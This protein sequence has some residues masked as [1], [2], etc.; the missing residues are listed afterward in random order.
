MSTRNI[1]ELDSELY[2]TLL[3]ADRMDVVDS[4]LIS[5]AGADKIPPDT[6]NRTILIGLGGTGMKT[7]NHIKRVV[8]QKLQPQWTK[9][10]AFLA[11]DSDR[12]EFDKAAYLEEYEF[13]L[14]T[15]PGI[16]EAVDHGKK[17]YPSAWLP[18]VD[19]KKAKELHDYGG[20]GAGRKRLMGKMKIHFASADKRGVDQD[21]V[22]RISD[23]KA[24]RLASITDGAKYQ[25]YVIGSL[26]GG[27]CSGGFLEMPAMIRKALNMGSLVEINAMLYLPDTV[28][29]LQSEINIKKELMANGYASLKELNYFQGM[30][31]RDG[32]SEVWPNNDSAN[33]ELKLEST[34][35]FF[36]MPYLIGTIG[37]PKSDS[38]KVAR[39]TIAEFFISLLGN[40]IP[41]EAAE[42]AFLM[43]SFLN[44]AK[45]GINYKPNN[46]AYDNGEVEAPKTAH[47]FP[48]RYGTI[49]FAQASAPQQIIRAYTV[50]KACVRAGLCPISNQ[51]RKDRIAAGET[52]LP[53]LGE[54][55]Y[56]SP[57]ELNQQR[58]EILASLTA[59][60]SRFQSA[61]FSYAN[62]IPGGA[63]TW[64]AIREGTADDS[65]VKRTVDAFVNKATNSAASKAME[66]GVQE[67]FKKFRTAVKLYVEKNGPM[68]FYNLYHG[69][70]AAEDGG[71]AAKGI[72]EVLQL[73]VDDQHVETGNPNVWPNYKN[74][75]KQ[76]NNLTQE[77]VKAKGGLI[78][79]LVNTFNDD[80]TKQA[81]Q[82]TSAYNAMVN[83][84]INEKRREFMLGKNGILRKNFFEPADTLARQLYAFGKILEAMSRGY[85]ESGSK[86]DDYNTFT[87]V[88]DN[89]TEVNIAALNP[90]AHQWLQDEA[91]ENAA[92][93]EGAKVRKSLVD[94]FFDKTSEWLTV[95]DNLIK[96]TGG[97]VSLVSDDTPVAA[98][99]MFDQCL[100]EAI[101]TKMDVTVGNLFLQLDDRGVDYKTYAKQIVDELALK[102]Q[103]LLNVN[104]SHGGMDRH[105]YI[106]YP[107]SL[108]KN[109]P[110]I[111]AA[112]DAAA[113]QKF[114]KIGVYGTDYADSIMMYQMVAPFEIYHLNDLPAWEREYEVM[115]KNQ[116]HGLH[117]MS[118]DVKREVS[119]D[120]A[121]KY[122]E[123]TS[124]YDYPAITYR[125]NPQEK[126]ED[127]NICHEGQVRNAMD[128]VIDEAIKMGLLFCEQDDDGMYYVYRIRMDN[129]V[130]WDFDEDL[131]RID[132]KTEMYPM[133]A[134][135]I[136]TVAKQNRVK[137]ADITRPV[138]LAYAGQMSRGHVDAEWAWKYARRVLY[139]HRPMFIQIRDTI[140]RVRPWNE[141]VAEMNKALMNKYKPA[142]M[143][144]MMMAKVFFPDEDNIWLLNDEDGMETPV[145]NMSDSALN[146]L[147]RRDPMG[148]AIVEAGFSLYYIYTKLADK[149]SDEELDAALS[150]AKTVL[151]EYRDE[152]TLDEAFDFTDKMMKTQTKALL[153]MGADLE[154]PEKKPLKAFVN[155]MAAVEIEDEETIMAICDFYSK[156]KFW[157]K[158]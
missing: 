72:R 36:D 116:G 102:S 9:Y 101:T 145:V 19:E 77:I 106:M 103:P 35:D 34:D 93:V 17:E 56:S 148:A 137:L 150:Y 157:K 135:L 81:G 66:A 143:I 57:A 88:S 6:H 30:G 98:R 136:K 18:F 85:M 44:N 40:M 15:Q 155:K 29:A 45:Q 42:D 67:E 129:S 127:G 73:M 115:I 4:A 90:T 112:I 74:L 138:S 62:V 152:E 89:S 61:S 156:L 147:T 1:Y 111:A 113:Q 69:N 39:E 31:M 12:S 55:Q 21:I 37:G 23:M 49:G 64:D 144:R 43:N 41:P 7:L 75:E 24:N 26:S 123:F 54:K 131:L 124:W 2:G 126:D 5:T 95:D 100:G 13:V 99:K 105:C 110:A 146:R 94:S 125:A 71:K 158:V 65:G 87:K 70:A 32:H 8:Q 153:A 27:T 133:G 80:R 86:L 10:I 91:S 121:V 14:S 11:I 28:M 108:K 46:S 58:Q 139:A 60:M 76:K 25:V 84:Q 114:G 16:K 79:T 142:K 130:D 117:G 52:F 53:F 140:D 132:P 59:F 48:R 141:A 83:A 3:A 82:W 22:S 118:P 128:K 78:G 51:E 154:N 107:Q 151:D 92:R 122:T 47:E 134:D 109:N 104:P 149:T 97:T 20:D 33:R 38:D 96:T 63:P 50:G 119:K 68:A 120:G